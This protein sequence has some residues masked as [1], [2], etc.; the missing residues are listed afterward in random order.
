VSLETNLKNLATR[1][2]TAIKA[3]G[4]Q[5]NGNAADLSAL[6]TTDKTHL[7]AAINEVL[8][9]MAAGGGAAI[10]DATTSTSKVWSSSKT[11]AE[12][13]TKIAA[14][15]ASAPGA[16]D[17]LDELAAALGDDA[18]FA[19]TVNTAIGNRVRY[20]AAQTLTA[21]QQAQARANIGALSAVEIGNPEANLVA[22]FEAGLL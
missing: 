14:L 16:L 6:Q 1:I 17:T 7:V 4:M 10:D 21:A 13:S 8:S 9:R 5:I 15:V 3:K 22:T 12:I 20:D 2:A 11:S 19:A 18:N